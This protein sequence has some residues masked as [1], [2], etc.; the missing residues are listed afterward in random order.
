M[1]TPCS[2]I[3]SQASDAVA[4]S[5]L[6]STSLENGVARLP[7]VFSFPTPSSAGPG[8]WSSRKKTSPFA[9][10]D[11]GADFFVWWIRSVRA[12]STSQEKSCADFSS[13]TSRPRRV[14]GR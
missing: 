8:D 10:S 13:I 1:L 14:D 9:S 11:V 2:W 12:S 7:S 6:V 5:R 3:V 4:S